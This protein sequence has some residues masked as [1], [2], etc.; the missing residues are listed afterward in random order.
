LYIL[1]FIAAIAFGAFSAF[2]SQRSFG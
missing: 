1:I 2:L